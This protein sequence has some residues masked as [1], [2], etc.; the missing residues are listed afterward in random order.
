LAGVSWS[1]RTLALVAAVVLAAIATVALVSYV[2]SANNKNKNKQTLVNV[3]VAKQLIPAGQS[4]D[5]A[6][7]Q[8]LFQT[9]QVPALA[10]SDDAITSLDQI[11]GEQA[12]VDIQKNEQILRSRFALAGSGNG[13]TGA[14]KL[15]LPANLQ[16]ISIQVAVPPGVANFIQVGDFVSVIA[17]VDLQL[18]N[19]QTSG[20][21]AGYVA[22]DVQVLAVGALQTTAATNGNPAS[23]S[24]VQPQGN[25]L[26]TLAVNPAQAQRLVLGTLDGALYFTI[27]P[28]GQKPANV[29]GRL[30]TNIFG[31]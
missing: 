26:V 19:G 25:V 28:K 21:V 12:L 27:V 5:T 22:Q 20:K 17:D 13:Q 8:G 14:L 7:S 15:N 24:V 3:F 30:K 16:A 11:K 23:T 29:I 9:I 18:P 4:A 6:I 2:Q 1:R 31:R 10:R